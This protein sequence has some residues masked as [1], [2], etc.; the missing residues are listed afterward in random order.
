MRYPKFNPFIYL[1][2]FVISFASFTSSYSSSIKCSDSQTLALLHFKQNLSSI[3]FSTE[4][5]PCKGWL[6]SSYYPIMMNWTISTDCCH[7]NGVTCDH[8]TGD[9][10]G[11]DLSCGM[12]QGSIHPSTSLFDLPHLKSLNLAFNDFTDSQLPPQIGRFSNSLTYLNISS[13][14]LSGRVPTDITLLHKLESLDLSLDWDSLN[15]EPHVFINMLQNTTN[16]KELSL[17][18]VNISSSLPTYLNVSSSLKLLDLGHT[19]LYGRL[20]HNI[21]NLRSL[22]KLDLSYNWFE[23]D[24]PREMSLLPNLVFLDL[25]WPRSDLQMEPYILN[26]LFGNSTSLEHLSL[27]E[28]NIFGALP[29]YL[30]TTSLKSLDLRWT[31]LEGK[32]PNNILNLPQLQQL[33][34]SWNSNL[35]GPFPTINTSTII[36]LEVLDL[37]STKLSTEIPGSIDHIKSLNYL[38]LSRCSLVGSLPKS[39]VNLKQLSFLDLSYNMLNASLPSWFKNLSSLEYILLHNNMFSGTV[40]FDSFPLQSLKQLALG[41]NQFDGRIDVLDQGPILH[42]FR[43]LT[44]LISL[45]LSFNNFRGEWELDTVL[46]SLTNLTELILSNSGLS[47]MTNTVNRYA[48]PGVGALYLAFC[49]VKVFPES[50]RAMKDLRYLDLSN[51]LIR[52]DIPEWAVEIGGNGMVGLDL[53]NNSLTGLPQL[54]WEGLDHMYL[55]S[56]TIQGPFPRSICNMSNLRYLDISNNS[57]GGVIP[58]C[59]GDVIISAVT[60]NLGNN[61]FQGTIPNVY[62]NCGPLEGLFLNGNQLEGEIPRSLSKCQFLKVLDVGNNHLN[63]TFPGWLGDL[64]KLQVLIL[65]SN[66]LSGPIV[67]S[68]TVES[69]F[70]SL[71]VLDLSYNEFVG[72]L[73]KNYF[74]NFNAMKNVTK[75]NRKLEYL[76][77]GGN[78]YSIVVV[79]K[80]VERSMPQIFVDYTIIDLSNNKFEGEIPNIIGSLTSLMVLNLAHNNL[81]GRIPSS[82]GK[83]LEM[84]SLDLSWNQLT[85]EIPRSL[86][87][88]TFLG[89]LNLSQNHLVGRIPQGSQFNTFEGNSFEGNEKLCGLPLPKKCEGSLKP[90]IKAD[91]DEESGFTWKAVILGYGCGTPLGIVIGYIMLTTR[92]VKWFNAIVDA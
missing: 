19:N 72:Q 73:P 22:E 18:R 2:F 6:G 12:L 81:I 53:S 91:G 13:C 49:N 66:K 87:D 33:D 14:S 70:P 83:L 26:N 67:T 77:S 3:N 64:P 5:S 92:R 21:F 76:E 60:I 46:S 27:V 86:A 35:T 82:I 28:V 71:L 37:T 55:K 75:N 69:L 89:F 8:S 90:Q 44:N 23:G 57:F 79:S 25:S 42:T 9:I 32:L 59:V 7:W 78:Y 54:L 61:R 50:L 40:Q 74:Q 20:P 45:D 1:L 65:K 41:Y 11:L 29:T 63:G 85:G 38:S 24:I 43:Q 17:N 80:G 47:V 15:F 68:S 56:N 48:N 36:R 88:L 4:Y 39:L 31:G 51:N 16:L 84:E 58:S 10:I 62:E 34:L 30:N 52:G